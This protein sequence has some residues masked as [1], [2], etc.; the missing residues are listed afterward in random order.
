L[1][2]ADEG[3]IRF[4]AG[5]ADGFDL[6]AAEAV[7]KAREQH[8]HLQLEI[9]LPYPEFGKNKPHRA[10]ILKQADEVKVIS[11]QYHP[12]CFRLRN[13]ALLEGAH[14]LLFYNHQNSGGTVQTAS[15]ADK[16]GIP[17]RPLEL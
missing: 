7:I 11:P 10:E 6:L 12:N 14:L 17:L 1:S 16:L 3:F 8:P 15:M 13:E 5:G 9:L 4:R 2:L